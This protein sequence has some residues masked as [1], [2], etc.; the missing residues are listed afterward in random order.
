MA[1]MNV[2]SSKGRESQGDIV[3]VVVAGVTTCQSGDR[4]GRI[5]GRRGTGDRMHDP[6]V[7][8]MQDAETV[9]GILRER[10]RKCL[11]CEELYRQLFNP[12]LYLMACGRIYASRGV[13]TAWASQET[14]ASL[15]L[16]FFDQGLGDRLRGDFGLS[17]GIRLERQARRFVPVTIAAG[18]TAGEAADHLLATK[19]LRK[20]T[21]RIEVAAGDLRELRNDISALWDSSFAGTTPAKSLRVLDGQIR[22]LGQV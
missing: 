12:Q 13:M 5:T 4:E 22:S 18:G 11:P 19:V 9:L 16:E 20:L 15:V 8:E 17:W 14:A 3:P 6:E 2:G 21:G 7:C 1:E 10:G